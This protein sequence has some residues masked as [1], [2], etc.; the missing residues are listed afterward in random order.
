MLLNN[1]GNSSLPLMNL[2]LQNEL[3]LASMKQG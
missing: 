1:H 2:H 3:R